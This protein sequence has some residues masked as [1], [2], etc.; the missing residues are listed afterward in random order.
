MTLEGFGSCSEATVGTNQSTA[1]KTS[2]THT[3]TILT[4]NHHRSQVH[5]FLLVNQCIDIT[6]DDLP[7][8][9]KEH[10]MSWE[11]DM[12]SWS[13]GNLVKSAKKPQLY[14]LDSLTLKLVQL[15]ATVQAQCLRCFKYMSA[16]PQSLVSCLYYYSYLIC[17]NTLFLQVFKIQKRT[18]Q[19]HLQG[20]LY[21]PDGR[22]L[23]KMPASLMALNSFTASYCL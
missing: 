15:Y 12:T 9:R 20:A 22:T 10:H 4:M 6:N 19:C 5:S 1:V 18:E 23:S 3:R 17:W 8:L 14:Q 7:T 2:Q 11:V 21:S 16:P 13:P